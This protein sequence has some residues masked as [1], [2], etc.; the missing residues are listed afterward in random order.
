MDKQMFNRFENGKLA[1]EGKNIEIS[2][3]P[4][5]E[6]TN[7]K[8]VFLKNIVAAEHTKGLLTCHLVHIEPGRKIGSHTHPINIELHEVI[9][10][11]GKCITEFGEIPYTKGVIAILPENSPHEVLAGE[12]GLYLF[13]KFINT[14]K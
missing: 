3:I 12:S 13:A 11:Y 8:G 5:N 4:W 14:Q 2:A 1:I 10:G 7:F 6:H 9:A